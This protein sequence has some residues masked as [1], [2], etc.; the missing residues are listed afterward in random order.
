MIDVAFNY[1]IEPY[2]L[3]I[4]SLKCGCGGGDLSFLFIKDDNAIRCLECK[5]QHPQIQCI[6]K[7][8]KLNKKV[9]NFIDRMV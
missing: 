8:I 2:S 7:I 9:Y 5:F 1:Q 4:S 6:I 3:I